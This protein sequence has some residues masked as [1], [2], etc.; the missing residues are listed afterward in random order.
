[1]RLTAIVVLFLVAVSRVGRGQEPSLDRAMRASVEVGLA[2]R[3]V[4]SA[5]VWS[6]PAAP[7]GAP[8][9]RPLRVAPAPRP[10][11]RL[12]VAPLATLEDS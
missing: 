5:P 4:A 1:M 2:A 10:Q 7:R 9:V 6:L 3:S 12:L 11:A 8:A